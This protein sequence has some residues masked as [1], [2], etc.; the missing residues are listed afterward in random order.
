MK[1]QIS[2]QLRY[3]SRGIIEFQTEYLTATI[4]TSINTTMLIETGHVLNVGPWSRAYNLIKITI[5]VTS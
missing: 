1:W 4:R 3:N 5:R 2:R